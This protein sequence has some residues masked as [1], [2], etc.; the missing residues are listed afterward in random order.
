M[1]DDARRG[2]KAIWTIPTKRPIAGVQFVSH[3]GPMSPSEAVPSTA[4]ASRFDVL[5]VGTT[6]VGRSLAAER[7]LRAGSGWTA[8]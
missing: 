4:V 7:L 3:T 2:Q 1:A 6:N 8:P 5:L